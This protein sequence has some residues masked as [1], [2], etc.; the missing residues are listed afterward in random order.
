MAASAANA[1]LM[2]DDNGSGD[3]GGGGSG[4][5][6]GGG[7]SGGDGGGK[8]GGGD[9]QDDL[10]GDDPASKKADEKKADDKGGGDKAGDY[11]VDVPKELADFADKDA[12]TAFTKL[13]KEQGLT[14]AQADAVAKQAF[15]RAKAGRELAQKTMDDAAKAWFDEIK[16]DKEI[17]GDNIPQTKQD[18]ALAIKKYA[19]PEFVKMAKEF[20]VQSWPPLVR[21]LQAI[22]KDLR[23]DS[24]KI[25]GGK[26]GSAKEE[27]HDEQLARIYGTS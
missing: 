2:G 26:G 27:T 13:A 19:P 23:P 4:G 24:G 11:T 18:I 21:L 15:E 12:L 9:S 16:N 5:D 8:S 6:N 1:D 7:G 10:L 17:G 22:G 20:G 25:Q 14:K 3:A